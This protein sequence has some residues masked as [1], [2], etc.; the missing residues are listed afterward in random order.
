MNSR[1]CKQLF[2]VALYLV[3]FFINMCVI[4]KCVQN[5]V[6]LW[7]PVSFHHIITIPIYTSGSLMH[8]MSSSC[9]QEISTW[10]TVTFISSWEFQVFLLEVFIQ[11]STVND[12]LEQCWQFKIPVVK[13]LRTGWSQGMLAIIRCK[14]FCVPVCYQ[15]IKIKL[16]RTIMM[17]VI[18]C[19]CETWSLTLREE[20]RLRVF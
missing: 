19:G 13:K 1:K 9:W 20:H 6:K 14:I 10:C 7:N 17:L 5:N 3:H 4:S 15:N 16:Y 18:L 11:W 12:I 2:L 8:L